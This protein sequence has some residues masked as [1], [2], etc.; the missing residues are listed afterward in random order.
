MLQDEHHAGERSKYR[1]WWWLQALNGVS[2]ESSMEG[3]NVHLEWGHSNTS[4]QTRSE[5]G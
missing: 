4:N 2:D 5:K 3:S 1:R